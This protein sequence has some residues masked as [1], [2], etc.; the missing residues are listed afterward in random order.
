MA[1]LLE[2]AV[3][4]LTITL[5]NIDHVKNLAKLLNEKIEDA[6]EWKETERCSIRD[7]I[8]YDYSLESSNNVE[9]VFEF[10]EYENGSY[11]G[12]QLS[13]KFSYIAPGASS[14][15]IITYTRKS[16]LIEGVIK[17]NVQGPNFSP[18]EKEAPELYDDF[19]RWLVEVGEDL[20]SEYML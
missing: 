2:E 4:N 15:V 7:E 8:M 11:L 17:T 6:E 5:H 12:D 20:F 10:F 16:E 13:A 3:Y 9:G 18:C 1:L 14:P 19:L